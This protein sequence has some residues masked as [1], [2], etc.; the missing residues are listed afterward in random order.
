MRTMYIMLAAV[1]WVWFAVAGSYLWFRLRPRTAESR[2][3]EPQTVEP[4][5]HQEAGRDE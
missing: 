3:T 1:G 5:G 4:C 2:T